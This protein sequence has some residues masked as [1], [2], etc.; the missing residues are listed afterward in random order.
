MLTILLLDAEPGTDFGLQ[1]LFCFCIV[2]W[3]FIV[4]SQSP[5]FLVLVLGTENQSSSKTIQILRKE[6]KNHVCLRSRGLNQI[7]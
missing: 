2:N 3:Y 4:L 7:L 5:T 6:K 1:I